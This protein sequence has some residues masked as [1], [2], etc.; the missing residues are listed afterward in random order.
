MILYFAYLLVH[1]GKAG[2]VVRNKLIGSIAFDTI[3]FLWRDNRPE[4][5]K[6]TKRWV[7]LVKTKRA[8]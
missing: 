2:K 4:E 5:K 3:P 8:K 6:R 7:D 1:V